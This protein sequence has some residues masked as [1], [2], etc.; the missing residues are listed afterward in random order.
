MILSSELMPGQK[1]DFYRNRITWTK[2]EDG[3]VTQLW[4]IVDKQD[5]LLSIA[6]KGIYKQK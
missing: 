5:K 3:S 2:N 4:E 1:I 6:F